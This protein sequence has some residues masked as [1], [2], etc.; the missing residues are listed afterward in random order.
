[1]NQEFS[2]CEENVSY[3]IKNPSI[4]PMIPQET[5][6]QVQL[7]PLKQFPQVPPQQAQEPSSAGSPQS[8]TPHKPPL[9]KSATLRPATPKPKK[10]RVPRRPP[11]QVWRWSFLWVGAF[12][13]AGGIGTGALLW[14]TNLPPAPDCQKITSLSL[15]ME[16]LYCARE[17]A[18]SGKA[19]DLIVGLELVSGWT[20]DQPLYSDAQELLGDWSNA[21]FALARTNVEQGNLKDALALTR[22][23]PKNSTIYAQVQEAIASWQEEWKQGEALLAIAQLDLKNQNWKQASAQVTELGKLNHSYWQRH[24]V[25]ELTRQIGM[26]RD[27]WETLATARKLTTGGAVEQLGAAIALVQQIR[28]HTYAGVEAQSSLQTWTQALVAASLQQWRQGNL[29]KAIALAQDIPLNQEIPAAAKDLVRF[30]YATKLNPL[31][32]LQFQPSLVQIWQLQEAIAALHQIAPDSPFYGLAQA[33]LQDWEPQAQ[34]LTQLHYA[35]LIAHLGHRTTFELAIAQAN[36]IAPDHPGRVQAQSLIAYWHQQIE[37]IEDQPYLLQARD[38][39]RVGSIPAL[40]QAMAVAQQVPAGRALHQDA[41][42]AIADWQAQ[43]EIIEDKPWLVK[44]L[45][46][47]KAN[48]LSDA[49]QE[50]AKIRSGRALYHEAQVAIA[51]WQAQIRA[52]Q[53]AEDRRILDEAVALAAKTHLSEAIDVAS[54]IG[55]GRP[56]RDEAQGAIAQWEDERNSI[57]ES[58][59]TQDQ[60]GDTAAPAPEESNPGDSYDGGQ[61]Q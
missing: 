42:A 15:D 43:I 18:Q 5:G 16:R 29:T 45:A 47:A 31:D 26:E 41:Q 35:N 1:V 56:L 36:L 12:F 52:V 8:S 25:I 10:H 11:A 2:S 27:A 53:V 21:L 9:K 51:D 59:S 28:P 19:A 48:K 40:R 50:A 17:A 60:Q 34:D 7:L 44:A 37:R 22:H 58:W 3:T 14:L 55:V 13:V 4:P 32:T 20:A 33:K 54:Q 30:S 23:I 46:L 57:W 38:L 6:K 24:Q 49:I 39:A 61:A